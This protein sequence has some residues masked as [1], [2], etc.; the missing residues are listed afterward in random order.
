M[1]DYAKT[2]ALKAQKFEESWF[3]HLRISRLLKKE[4]SEGCALEKLINNRLSKMFL[5]E[6]NHLFQLVYTDVYG[7]SELFIIPRRC[8]FLH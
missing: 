6:T 8:L 7:P 4:N 2:T 1:F 3:C 5:G